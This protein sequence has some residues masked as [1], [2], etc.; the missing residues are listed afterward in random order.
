[1]D[2]QTHAQRQSSPLL[3]RW[4]RLASTMA[5]AIPFGSLLPSA[6]FLAPF[7]RSDPREGARPNSLLVFLPGIQS[8]PLA[9]PFEPLIARARQAG[10]DADAVEVDVHSRFL[11]RHTVVER[12]K[13]EIIDAARREGYTEIWLVGVSMGGAGA[14]AYAREHP[15]SIEGIV[16]LGPYLGHRRFIE[17]LRAPRAD[18]H[19]PT[20]QEFQHGLWEWLAGPSPKPPIYLGFGSE[21]KYA[22][23]HRLISELLPR[24]RVFFL[25]G[26]HDWPT[27]FRLWE[28]IVPRMITHPRHWA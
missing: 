8:D 6:T 26:G 15:T 2:F 17:G 13:E 23:C 7:I 20:P 18:Y 14:L 27:W 12:L 19:A 25:P 5:L 16:L 9:A 3:R 10:L 4:R 11:L 22:A 1:M 24:G 28:T 21:D